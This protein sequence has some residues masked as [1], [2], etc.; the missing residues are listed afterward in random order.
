MVSVSISGAELCTTLG[1]LFTQAKVRM[2]FPVVSASKLISRK[3]W[4]PV[5][6]NSV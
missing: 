4:K 2:G 6:A 3:D 1:V 5:M